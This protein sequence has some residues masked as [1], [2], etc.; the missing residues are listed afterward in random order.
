[1]F[2]FLRSVSADAGLA[3]N[4]SAWPACALVL[5]LATLAVQGCARNASEQPEK[6]TARKVPTET[7]PSPPEPARENDASASHAAREDFERA[8]NQ[9]L[10][11]LDEQLRELE[12]KIANLKGTVTADWTE[13]LEALDA[14]RKAARSKLDEMRKS[15]GEAWEH[16]RQ[17]AHKA[18]DELEQAVSE[19][20]KAL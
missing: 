12:T 17:E 3:F 14:K 7:P 13:R 11:R 20:L 19:A 9:N 1:M 4:T 10:E 18:K 15:T 6:H 2:R 16:L 5:G 8:L